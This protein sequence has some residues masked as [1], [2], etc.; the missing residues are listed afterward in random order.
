ML[1]LDHEHLSL[2]KTM[3]GFVIFSIILLTTNY[4]EPIAADSVSIY[5]DKT[6]YHNG[7]EIIFFGTVEEAD[8]NEPVSVVV[9]DSQDNFVIMGS[10]LVTS[11]SKF[12][13]TVPTD[14]KFENKGMHT[15]TLFLNDLK[16]DEQ[17]YFDFSP[18]GSAVI[19][20]ESEKQLIQSINQY[21][22]FV[23]G[24][25]VDE[26]QVVDSFD[27]EIDITT[28]D[29]P[30]LI[31]ADVTN[32]EA[33][34][35][36][37]AYIIQIK[38]DENTTISISWITGVLSPDQTFDV[39]LSWTPEYAGLYNAEIYVWDQISEANALSEPQM[40]TLIVV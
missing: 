7:E 19:H 2:M 23:E 27:N 6:L 13:I 40:V 24:V 16:T 37:F 10:S 17:N 12:E 14:P 30:V 4:S 25:S 26:A 1:N 11:E 31:S 28:V 18:D 29:K 3:L 33:D 36:S 34:N 35:Q 22:T 32:L 38:D 39:S 20:T 9:R 15:A 21:K 5:T 8:F